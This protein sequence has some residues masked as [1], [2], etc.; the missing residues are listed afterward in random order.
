MPDRLSILCVHGIGHGDADPTLIPAWQNA[1]TAG[2]QRWAP[3][4]AVDFDFLRYDDEFDH[5]PLDPATYAAAVARLTASGIVHGIGDL[6]PGARGLFDLPDQVRWTAGMIAQ[7]ATEPRLRARLRTRV[8]DA[9]RGRRPDV[10]CAHSLGSLVCYD[11]FQRTPGAAAGAAFVSLGSQ[12]GNPF[13]RDCFAG[14]IGPLDARMW[15]HLYNPDDHVFTSEVR[16]QAANFVEIQTPF[17]KP[18]DPLN[19]DP[20]WYFDHA[21]TQARV[22]LDLA[23]GRP[24][25]A[26]GRDA[27][28]ARALGGG[29]ARRALLIGINAYPD[30]ANRLEGCVNDVFLMSAVLQE[31]GF[32]PEEIR[33]VLDERATAAGILERLHW[34]LDGVR[35]DDERVLFYSGHGAQIPAYGPRQE[36]DRLD[37]CL[38]P[39]DFDWSPARAV[40]DKQLVGLYSQLPYDSRFAAVFDC[41]HSGGLSREGGLRPRGIDPPDDV[42]H[43]ALRWDAGLRMWRSRSLPSPNRSLARGRGGAGYLGAEGATYRIGRGV[44][45]RGLPKRVYDRERRALRHHGPYLPIIVEACQEQELSYEYRDGATSYGAFTYSL[46]KVLRESRDRGDN[47]SFRTLVRLTAARLRELD[48]EQTPALVGPRNLLGRPIPWVGGRGRRRPA[49]G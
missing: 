21:G 4:L 39:H 30:P 11:A 20:V 15:Y 24:A 44:S 14:R 28:V 16:V 1:I 27:R 42:R 46:A 38:V 6:L 40:T 3:G 8:L 33:V 29:P 5:A 25:R 10:V 32:Q 22:W 47:P 17:D 18:G 12:I 13:V 36:V 23:G 41:C 37:E 9:M 34:L 48:Y 19:H 26:F 2:L 31:C 43:R 7:W 35:G 49:R 45:L